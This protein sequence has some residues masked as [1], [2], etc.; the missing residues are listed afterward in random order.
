MSGIAGGSPEV[1]IDTVSVSV[2]VKNSGAKAGD[3]V[4]QLYVSTVAPREP[5]ALKNLRGMERVTL[6]PGESRRVSFKVVPDKD[7]THYDVN[8]KRYAVDAK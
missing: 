3:E 2:N 7:F 5:R 8:A 1:G 4:V 6:K